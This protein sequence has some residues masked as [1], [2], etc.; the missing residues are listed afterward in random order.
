MTKLA[1]MTGMR[2]SEIVALRWKDIDLIGGCIHLERS[3]RP[4]NGETRPKNGE[5]RTV[6]LVSE[7]AKVLEDWVQHVGVQ[8][9]DHLVFVSPRGGTYVFGP[10]LTSRL[11]DAM[12]QAGIERVGERGV[13]RDFHSLR[14]TFARSILESGKVT[15]DWTM[16]QMGHSSI[17]IT[18]STYGMWSRS[19]EREQAK[20]LS[21]IYAGTV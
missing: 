5:T 20:M 4:E 19:A 12:E 17:N 7:A 18:V 13:K 2:Q 21:G 15:L 11:F 6:W 3:Y 9:S 8:P 1:A 14:H 10:Y 16:R